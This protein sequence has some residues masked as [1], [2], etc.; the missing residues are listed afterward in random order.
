MNNIKKSIIVIL[1]III[2]LAI[3][4]ISI[5]KKY[6]DKPHEEFSMPYGDERIIQK[7]I[8]RVNK[9]IDYYSI[10]LIAQSYLESIISQDTDTLYNILDLDT[11]KQE[12]IN[13][14][15][16]I[17][18]LDNTIIKEDNDI[19]HYRFIIEDMYLS[20]S[21]GNIVTYFVYVKVINSKSEKVMPTSFMVETDIENDT[22]YILPY[23]YMYNKGYLNI[24]EGKEYKTNITKIE[25][26][27]YNEIEYDEPDEYT[28]ILNLMSKL[29][30]E[31]VYDLDNSYNLFS[32]EYKK[33]KFDTLDEY[34]K[35]M[36]KNI[37]YIIS[38]SIEKYQINEFDEYTEYICIDQYGNYYIFK[39]T[40][41][42]NYTLQLDTYT[43]DSQEF[44]E[45]YNKG[46]EQLKVGMNLE[47]IFQALNR[48]D[49]EYIYKKLHNTFKTNN[50][51][52]LQSF[53]DY[54]EENFFDMNKI[55]YGKFEEKSGVYIY[56]V[57]IT[58]ATEIEENT[59][60]KSFIVQLNEGT[61]FA[62]S[63]NK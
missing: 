61:D 38:S 48:K 21:D 31:L 2:I 53:E 18:K 52:T 20:E 62:I 22:Y 32:D 1:V 15:D 44:I 35:Y 26:N 58:D 3:I 14:D 29:T 54:M 10:K 11:M 5:L 39:E 12:N 42:M 46:S 28:I 56:E 63:F 45:K 24:E 41:V 33:A 57:N 4:I 34:K 37:R 8:T 30:D 23:E 7:E 43:I 25:N 13:K 16:I 9:N 51:P 36:K 47:K 49:Y 6:E 55:D 60:E 17:T 19:E 27:S 50:F 59:I 40:G